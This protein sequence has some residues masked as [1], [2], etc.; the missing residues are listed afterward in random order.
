MVGEHISQK[1]IFKFIP[2]QKELDMQRSRPK[3]LANRQRQQL[4]KLLLNQF[5]GD[6]ELSGMGS[7]KKDHVFFVVLAFPVPYVGFGW[8]KLAPHNSFSG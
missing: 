1:G 5:Q 2:D 8:L 3:G 4:L 7:A 6:N